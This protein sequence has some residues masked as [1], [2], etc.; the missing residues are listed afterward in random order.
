MKNARAI[1]VMGVSGCGKTSVAEGLAASLGAAFI[2]GDSLHPAA[3]VDKMSHGIALTD[4]DRWPWL[5]RIV[6]WVADEDAQGHSTVVT[7]S[8]LK[9][10]YRDRLATAPGRTVFLHLVGSPELLGARMAARSGHFMPASLLPSQFA[11]LEPLELGTR[12]E[13]GFTIESAIPLAEQVSLAYRVV[14]PIESKN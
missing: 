12:G 10:A 4:E 7:C 11:T 9:R 13:H 14:G 6:T 5:D 3:N 2:E 8:A 1:V